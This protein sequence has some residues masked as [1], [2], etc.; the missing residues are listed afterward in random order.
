M[1]KV[2]IQEII[3]EVIINNNTKS[4]IILFLKCAPV[5]S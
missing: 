1:L 3:L 5:Y 4:Q 2:D